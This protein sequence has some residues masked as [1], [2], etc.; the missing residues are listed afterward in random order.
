MHIRPAPL[1]LVFGAVVGVVVSQPAAAFESLSCPWRDIPGWQH[2][3]GKD[4]SCHSL[5]LP[6]S[7]FP[8]L[9]NCSTIWEIRHWDT[10]E[11]DMHT[12]IWL[13]TLLCTS[14]WQRRIILKETIKPIWQFI[15]TKLGIKLNVQDSLCRAW[16]FLE[17]T[18]PWNDIAGSL[19]APKV[20]SCFAND[21]M[22]CEEGKDTKWFT[23]SI[24]SVSDLEFTKPWFEVVECSSCPVSVI[25]I[26][27]EFSSYKGRWSWSVICFHFTLMN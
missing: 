4:D 14:L 26:N 11:A 24:K 10:R 22:G 15:E 21:H 20:T 23:K 2:R 8:F 5:K 9:F 17:M 13:Q 16:T 25:W 19:K 27:L 1:G 12:A 18:F 7:L 6:E 3:Q